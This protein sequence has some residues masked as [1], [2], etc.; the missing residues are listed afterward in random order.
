VS[1]ERRIAPDGSVHYHVHLVD[2][3][4]IRDS[5]SYHLITEVRAAESPEE[6]AA[7]LVRR[8]PWLLAL[9]MWL[10][11]NSDYADWL[12]LVVAVILHFTPSPADSEPP[13]P[14]S[15]TQV[16]EI[17]LEKLEE[18]QKADTSAPPP[19]PTGTA[20]PPSP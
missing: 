1:T 8:A 6:A 2:E 16:E 10:K 9:A 3:V 19:E 13:P 12:N 20:P 4:A 15:P 7:I 11:G 5:L 17:I 14:P 18:L